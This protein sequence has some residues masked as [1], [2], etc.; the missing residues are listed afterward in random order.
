MREITVCASATSVS[1]QSAHVLKMYEQLICFKPLNN[2]KYFA[3]A[4][5]ILEADNFLVNIFCSFFLALPSVYR[6]VMFTSAPF[7][8]LRADLSAL[9]T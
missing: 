3:L 6:A 7:T 2:I 4:I 9:K 1:V 5:S 8:N